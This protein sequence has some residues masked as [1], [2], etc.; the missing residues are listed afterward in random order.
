MEMRGREEG[1]GRIIWGKK[2]G[3]EENFARAP[4]Q[5]ERKEVRARGEVYLSVHPSKMSSDAPMSVSG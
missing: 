1:E 5:E 3:D 2:E 4:P